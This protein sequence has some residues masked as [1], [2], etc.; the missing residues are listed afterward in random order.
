ML[1][2]THAH[3]DDKQFDADREEIIARSFGGGVEKI[4]NIGA[5]L[6]S[7]RRS[8]ELAEK[9]ENIFAAVGLHPHYFMKHETWGAEHKNQ[10]RELARESKVV[11]IGEVGLEYHFPDNATSEE[12]QNVLKMKQ[13]E[14]FLFQI[15]LAIELDLPL[16]IHCR[17]AYKETLE[18]LIEE[19][20][21]Y[22][23]KLRGVLHSYL[24]R[25]SYA[26][27]FVN[28]DFL[29]GFNGIITYARDY[30]KVIR[31]AGLGNMLLET[32]C[33]YLTPAPHKNERN[34]PAYVKYAAEKIAEIKGV[35]FEEVARATTE[36][37]QKLFGVDFF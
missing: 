26:K 32:D 14:G 1:I 24:G 28:L 8:V 23:G 7:S 27:E 12:Q 4:I 31:E 30:D 18:I 10:L 20:K 15:D 25:S 5:G 36:N 11:A 9:H 2:D 37:A 19:K 33:P 16:I 17:E 29:L 3:L 13:K 34:E 6:G 21:K 35:S 22:G